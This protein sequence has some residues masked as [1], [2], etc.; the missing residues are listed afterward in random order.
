MM[1]KHE[2][3]VG[4]YKKMLQ[5]AWKEKDGGMEVIAYDNLSLE[6]FY[7]GEITKSNY[8]HD[9]I[10]RGKMENDMSIVKKI[11]CNLLT[12]KREQRHNLEL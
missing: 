12:S 3:A 7:L 9:R 10:M 1:K 4:T 11:F 5:L 2:E 6:Y 8:Y